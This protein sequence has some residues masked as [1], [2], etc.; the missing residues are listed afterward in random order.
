MLLLGVVV[1]SIPTILHKFSRLRRA[2]EL[3]SVPFREQSTSIA[4][5][6]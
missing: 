3:L 5:D 1:F 6:N 4:R 2:V